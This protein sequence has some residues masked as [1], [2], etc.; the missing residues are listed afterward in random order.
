MMDFLKG[1]DMLVQDHPGVRSWVD[2]VGDVAC[3][4]EDVL[5]EF[6]MRCSYHARS[7]RIHEIRN[8]I[9]D[10]SETHERY[11]SIL[12]SFMIREITV[13]ESFKDAIKRLFKEERQQLPQELAPMDINSLKSVVKD[14]LQTKKCIVVFDY[15]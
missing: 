14:F 5:D 2:Q 3:D 8:R 15:H 11:N 10:I 13:S 12:S 9:S 4:V 6:V 1:A 7:T